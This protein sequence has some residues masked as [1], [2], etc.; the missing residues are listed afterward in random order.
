MIRIGKMTDYGIV[1]LS[2]FVHD[3]KKAH[4]ARDLSLESSLPLP[5]VSKILKGLS[6]AELLVSQRGVKGGYRLAFKPESISVATI[7]QALEG[8]IAMTATAKGI[9]V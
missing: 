7:I 1:L 3:E 9:S 6:R 5:T 4:N 8:P 2:Y